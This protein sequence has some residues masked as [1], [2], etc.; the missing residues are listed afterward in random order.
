MVDPNHVD[1][2]EQGPESAYPPSEAICRHVR[3]VIKWVAPALPI[4][5]EVIRR[6]ASQGHRVQILI[7]AKNAGM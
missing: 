7:E 5:G 1:Q 3:P 6:H 2:S 4:A